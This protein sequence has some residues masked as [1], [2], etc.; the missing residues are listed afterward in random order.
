MIRIPKL[1]EDEPLHNL[2]IEP[3]TFMTLE[4]AKKPKMRSCCLELLNPIPCL[5]VPNV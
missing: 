5:M 2:P 4:A 1:L 3:Y